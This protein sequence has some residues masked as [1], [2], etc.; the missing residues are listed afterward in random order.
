MDRIF[1]LDSEFLARG[2]EWV[3]PTCPPPAAGAEAAHRRAVNAK[4][5]DLVRGMLPAASLSHMGIFASGQAYEQL[6]LH[7]LAHPLAEAR[8]YGE[9]ILTDLEAVVPS[10][11]TRVRRPERGGVWIDQLRARR[12]RAIETAERLGLRGDASAEP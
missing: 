10:F 5:L 2:R 1:K 4:A 12:E 3:A 9:M 7:L 8:D 6:I 11:L